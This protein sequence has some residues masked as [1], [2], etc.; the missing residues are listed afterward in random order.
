MQKKGKIKYTDPDRAYGYIVPDDCE[1]PSETVLFEVEDVEEGLE[2][3]SPGSEVVYE[4]DAA[5]KSQARQVR[6]ADS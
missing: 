6:S 3:L 1:D 5:S 4:V 2:D